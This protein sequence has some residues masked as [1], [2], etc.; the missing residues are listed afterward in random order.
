MY[1]FDSQLYYKTLKG[2]DPVFSSQCQIQT[3]DVTWSFCGK[4]QKLQLRSIAL[5]PSGLNPNKTLQEA[6][7]ALDLIPDVVLLFWILHQ[8]VGQVHGW[9]QAP[10]LLAHL[11]QHPIGLYGQHCAL[12][13][14]KKRRHHTSRM[15][16]PPLLLTTKQVTSLFWSP[17]SQ[18]NCLL[19]Q[20]SQG[21]AHTPHGHECSLFCLQEPSH[22]SVGTCSLSTSWA[23]SL[24]EG[25]L[26]P[27]EQTL[28][29]KEICSTR[30]KWLDTRGNCK[31]PRTNI[32]GVQLA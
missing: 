18:A 9:Y 20:M 19:F 6:H 7:P 16:V 15:A 27:K 12:E 26:S 30:A 1:Y 31:W 24:Q 2:R 28:P 11:H 14:P 22:L 13:N 4:R 32:P 17:A 25:I 3:T 8:D 5:F 10:D 23:H 21:K 29:I